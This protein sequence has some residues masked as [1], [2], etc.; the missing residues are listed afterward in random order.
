[1]QRRA[2][3]CT[4]VVALAAA[5]ACW[6]GC[7][8]PA[9]GPAGQ[10]SS[11]GVT[12]S[13]AKRIAENEPPRIEVSITCPEQVDV[14][15]KFLG[16]I[17]IDN[18]GRFPVS[19]LVAKAR[20]D[21]G[22]T[23]RQSA[24]PIERKVV[25]VGGGKTARIGVVLQATQ[26]GTFGC[27]VEVYLGDEI[28]ASTWTTVTAV[29]PGRETPAAEPAD[30]PAEEPGSPPRPDLGPPLVDNPDALQ[31][32]SPSYP[33]WFDKQNKSVVMV[34]TVCQQRAPLEL[35]ACLAGSKEH[36]SVVAVNTKAYVVHAGLLAAGAEP[37]AP[38]RFD[39]DYVPPTG[40]EIEVQVIWKDAEGKK[41]TAR[42]QDWVR[43]VQTGQP[44]SSPWVFTGS[45]FY[46]NKETGERFYRA[47]VEGDLIC[48]ANFPSAV[49]DVPVQSSDSDAA[50]MFDA[51]TEHIPARG[52][53]VT[54]V[55]T[56]KLKRP[57][58]PPAEAPKPEQP[59]PSLADEE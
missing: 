19:D 31:M 2:R 17:V 34:G 29:G 44:M 14:G 3:Q 52:T 27:T 47:D 58:Q 15:K 28:L 18:R 11:P 59:Q 36:E 35:F 21:S 12:H 38:V 39:P 5:G 30:Q 54:L 7:E 26:P 48:V 24:D 10:A 50:L 56:P 46:E 41:H 16:E 37:G 42:A 32:L 23:R 51:F 8:R 1:M 33:V 43:N 40:P 55:L 4:L 9:G 25:P 57:A 49:L 13:A 20:F 6:V 45:S 53:P 22:L